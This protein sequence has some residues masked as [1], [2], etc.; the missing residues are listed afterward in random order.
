MSLLD[1]S[2]T[3]VREVPTR[4]VMEGSR[5]PRRERRQASPARARGQPSL[6]PH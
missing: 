1:V 6:P 2:L 3:H 4:P 5:W